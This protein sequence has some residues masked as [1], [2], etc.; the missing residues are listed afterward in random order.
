MPMLARWR[1]Q[2]GETIQK[3]QGRQDQRHFPIGS[4]LGQLIH[5]APIRF[6]PGQP[7]AGEDRAS[8]IAQQAFECGSIP[9]GDPDLGIQGEAAAVAPLEYEFRDV[10]RQHRAALEQL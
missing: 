1:G 10:L 4:R 9:G 8:A 5:L 3:L 2:G 6:E 7:F